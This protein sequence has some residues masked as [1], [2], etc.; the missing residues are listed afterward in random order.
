M[1]LDRTVCRRIATIRALGAISI[2]LAVAIG[3]FAVYGTVQVFLTTST[4]N[5]I[6]IMVRNTPAYLLL[7]AV[8][9]VCLISTIV[10]L[11]KRAGETAR[12]AR[13]SAGECKRRR[14]GESACGNIDI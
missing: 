1:S 4:N 11:V 14:W 12:V 10:D 3:W 2:V 13:A 6:G 8:L 9:L 7:A 5:E